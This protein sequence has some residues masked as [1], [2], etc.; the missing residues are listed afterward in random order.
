MIL[1]MLE[2]VTDGFTRYGCVA[3]RIKTSCLTTAFLKI[4]SSVCLIA[5]P[6]LVILCVRLFTCVVVRLGSAKRQYN[7]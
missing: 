1:F 6:V 5:C 2:N 3:K 7:K 4:L